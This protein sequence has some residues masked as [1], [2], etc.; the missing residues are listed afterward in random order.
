M[1]RAKL[2]PKVVP[3]KAFL[4]VKS[5]LRFPSWLL[6]LLLVTMVVVAY[7]PTLK[8]GFIWDD[9]AHLTKNP[10]II[11]PLG[12]VGIWTSAAAT[13]YPLVLTSF[14]FEHALWGLSPLPFHVVNILVHASC[15][16]LLWRV[17]LRLRVTG[18]WLGAALWAMHPVQAESVAWITEMKNTQSCLFYLLTILCY[19]NWRNLAA[20]SPVQKRV[21]G[22]ALVLIFAACAILSK[23]S[24]VM[25][26]VILG[27]CAWWLDGRWNGRTV[28]S[29]IPLCAIS[30]AASG[31]TIWEQ[32]FHSGALGVEWAQTFAERLVTAGKIVWFY[33]GK[34]VWPHP[35]IFIYP[36]WA[37]ET[38]KIF[39]FV[40]VL[41]VG[42]GLGLLWWFRA[43]Q[44]RPV[45]FAVACFLV[46]LFPVLDF[47]NVYFFRYSFVGDHFQYLASMS[48]LALA[49]AGLSRLP[50]KWFMATGMGLVLILGSMTWQES[51]KYHDVKTLWR[52]TLE[53]NPDA[54]IAH[55]NL[56]NVLLDQGHPA[57]AIDHFRE[58]FLIKPDDAKCPNNLGYALLD[59]GQTAEA[60][61]LFQEAL[62]LEPDYVTAH[63]NLS[64]ALVKQE[65]FAE[66]IQ[67]C[68]RALQLDPDNSHDAA[69]AHSNLGY[70]LSRQGKWDEAIA[71][72][73]AAL[74]FDPNLALAYINLGNA[75]FVQRKWSEAIQHYKQDLQLKPEDA[76]ACNNIGMAL[77][78]Q[79]KTDAAM[80]YFQQSLKLAN[81]QHNDTLAEA[82]QTRLK[83]YPSA[84]APPP[85]P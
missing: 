36:R 44:S 39:S 76:D 64:L 13:Y 79:G 71:H 19:V 83:S 41:A 66:A 43:G 82:I 12:F 32:K 73:E 42:L 37:I 75:L 56:G 63:I 59:Q 40:P 7:L 45:F 30:G 10:C 72:Y 69:L 74:Q 25:L 78:N 6:G 1:R 26:P 23:A 20:N 67:H 53:K 5:A 35:L 14:W 33:P 17:L 58:A 49:A 8:G 70:A 80:P 24:T 85:I 3:P 48:L 18:A 11:G 62:R 22:Y 57:E 51:K 9:D 21:T 16:W 50:K 60:I 38:G 34:L 2:K 61:G 77:I 54:W 31:W 52:S 4:P 47:F 28:W 46:S 84:S 55:V 15:A 29:L 68:E 27:L 65:R 81:S